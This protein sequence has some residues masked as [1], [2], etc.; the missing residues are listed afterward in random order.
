MSRD[1][2]GKQQSSEIAQDRISGQQGGTSSQKGSG[3]NYQPGSQGSG[4][5]G[6]SA[7]A[8][9]PRRGSSPRSRGCAHSRVAS[10]AR[11]SPGMRCTRHCRILPSP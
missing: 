5:Q 2:Q 4:W 1:N 9:A 3:Q 11:T 8:L 6:S 10:S 7:S